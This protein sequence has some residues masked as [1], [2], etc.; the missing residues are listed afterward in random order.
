MSGLFG[1]TIS[2][3]DKQL[4]GMQVTRSSYGTA[5]PL[6]YGRM[7]VAGWLLDYLDFL[8][9]PHTSTTNTGGKGGGSTVKNTTYTYQATIILGICEGPIAGINAIYQDK[10]V[11]S[12]AGLGLTLFTG[13]GGQATWSF[14]TTNHASRAVPYDHTAYV[15]GAPFQLGASA[16]LPNLS[17]E[18]DGFLRYNPGGG[19]YDAEPSAIANDYLTDTNHG[20]GFPT[21]LIGSLTNWANYNIGMGFFLSPFEESQRAAQ[22]FITELC[23]VTNTAPVWTPSGLQFI[24]YGDTTVGSY[25]PNLTPAYNFTDDDYVPNGSDDPV[26]VT[27]KQ[28][29]DCYNQV[30]VEFLDR[31]AQYNTQL[32]TAQDLADIDLNGLRPAQIFTAHSITTAAVARTV[33]QL[34][35]QRSLYIKNTYTFRVRADYSLLDPM[36]VVTITESGLG[37]SQ[38]LCRVIEVNEQDDELELTVEEIQIGAASTVAIGTQ[39]SGGYAADYNTAPGAVQA[40]LIINAPAAIA[41]EGGGYESWIAVGGPNNGVWGGCN[42]WM[43]FDN[44]VYRQIGRMYGP[45]RYGTLQLPSRA[46]STAYTVGQLIQDS[47]GNTEQC[48]VAGTSGSGSPPTWP[49]VIGNTVADGGVTWKLVATGLVALPAGVDPDTVNVPQ[50]LLNNTTQTLGSGV[51]ADADQLRT[52]M[53]VDGELISYQTATLVSAGK[54]NLSGRLRRGNYGSANA[55]HA[56]GASF[57]RLDD[58]IFRVPYDQGLIGQTVYFKFQSFNIWGQALESLAS[59]TAYSH[60]LGGSNMTALPAVDQVGSQIV[61]QGVHNLIYNGFCTTGDNSNFTGL[62]V[63]GNA[64]TGPNT[65]VYG[66]PATISA[67]GHGL[68]NGATFTFPTGASVLAISDQAIPVNPNDLYELIVNASTDAV[69]APPS[70]GTIGTAK[71]V[72]D[73]AGSFNG[74]T[75]SYASPTPALNDIILI[76][77]DVHGGAGINGV[78]INTPTGYTSV[79]AAI[80]PTGNNWGQLFWRRSDGTDTGTVSITG[81]FNVGGVPTTN[82]NNKVTAQIFTFKGCITSGTPFEG[83]ATT[84]D[85]SSSTTVDQQAVTTTANSRMVLHF[86]FLS[87]AVTT[88]SYTGETGGDFTE[89]STYNDGTNTTGTLQVQTA[90]LATAGTITGGTYTVSISVVALYFGLALIPQTPVSVR[91]CTIGMMHYDKSGQQIQTQHAWR[92]RT[93]NTTVVSGGTI[94]STSVTV[95]GTGWPNYAAGDYI[96]FGIDTSAACTDLPNFECY[97]ITAVSTSGGNRVI[98]LGKALDAVF[99][100]GVN[101]GYSNGGGAPGINPIVLNNAQLPNALAQYRGTLVGANA[102][103][104]LPVAGQFY[105]GTAFLRFA[106]LLNISGG[107][108]ATWLSGLTLRQVTRTDPALGQSMLTRGSTPIQVPN[109]SFSYTQPAPGTSTTISWSGLSV[110]RADNTSTAISNSNQAVTGLTASTTYYAYPYYDDVNGG[111]VQFVTGGTG[112]PAILFTA[113]SVT[114]AQAQALQGRIPLSSGGFAVVTGGAGGGGGGSG[115]GSSCFHQSQVVT[116]RRGQ[117][118]ALELQVGDEVLTPEGWQA[119]AEIQTG[120]EARWIEVTLSTGEARLVTPSHLFRA[121]DGEWVSAEQLHLE[122]ILQ[123]DGGEFAAV[124][125][126]R[127]VYHA[128]QRV[129]FSVPCHEF[130]FEPGG[131]RSHNGTQKP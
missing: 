80:G 62:G 12:V 86:A 89:Y 108:G 66:S 119:I 39:A 88:S 124:T 97:P 81:S 75:P 16:A 123:R 17:F 26:V 64:L 15:A 87:A 13:A 109:T 125:A 51:Q 126:L 14:M 71:T 120:A 57:A 48:T 128:A 105:Q 3:K 77:V 19:N 29:A 42:V 45:S 68:N 36:D 96:T 35:M 78:T 61:Q 103:T 7:R 34:V 6:V 53:Y 101:V 44:S 106:A 8:G 54:Y 122:E 1:V 10:A 73:S 24:P 90:Q 46:A 121:A 9:V 129:S 127:V 116:T 112:S 130:F 25:T 43:S 40:P 38:Q 69:G 58:A 33:A 91:N 72:G 47:N 110:L 11:Q 111:N 107:T 28:Q 118:V 83:Y 117:V 21:A 20:V 67:S 55:N 49:T 100:A 37:L 95:T 82:V 18:V 23:T 63:S 79:G 102:L 94:G 31:S 76:S 2:T 93:Y 22:E 65:P 99:N 41:N 92:N 98:T 5:V 27:R 30:Q 60:V 85:S 131:V 52:L 70:N 84:V 59:D 50:V 56:N 104:T 114:A 115:G 113:K 74:L 32:A 4:N